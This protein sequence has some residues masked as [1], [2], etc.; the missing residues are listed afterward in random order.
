MLGSLSRVKR[1]IVNLDR[2]ALRVELLQFWRKRDMKPQDLELP[3]Y[4]DGRP[5]FV[6]GSATGLS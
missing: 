6:M 2:I 1:G 5:T 4:M 3:S